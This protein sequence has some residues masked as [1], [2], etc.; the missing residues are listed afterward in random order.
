MSIIESTFKILS[1]SLKKI[2]SCIKGAIMSEICQYEMQDNMICREQVFRN[3]KGENDPNE[4]CI[5]HSEDL[6]GKKYRFE[7]EFNRKLEKYSS[8]GL[9]NF[10]FSGYVFPKIPILAL[11]KYKFEKSVFFNNAVFYFSNTSFVNCSFLGDTTDFS[12]TKFL[13]GRTSFA[14]SKFEGKYTLFTEAYFSGNDIDFMDVIFNSNGTYFC[15]TKFFST[16]T[17]FLGTLFT[18]KYKAFIEAQFISE[19]T[20]FKNSNFSGEAVA[21]NMA[22]FSG[23]NLDFSTSKFTKNSYVSFTKCSFD[24]HLTDFTKVY[25][26]SE[27]TYF[28]D[29]NICSDLIDFSYSVFRGKCTFKPSHYEL[30]NLK[31]KEVFFADIKGFVEIFMVKRKY[32]KVKIPGINKKDKQKFV[33]LKFITD[34]IQPIFGDMSAS[35]Y[36]VAARNIKDDWFLMEF[37]QKHWG[38]YKL[39]D[40]L[41]DCGRGFLRW[42][43]WS[44]FIALFFTAIYNNIW[45]FTNG[46]FKSE[47]P[48]KVT[49]SFLQFLYYSVV[50]FTTLGFGDISPLYISLQLII[51][52]E[53]IFGYIML[54]GLIS[55]LAV[56]LARRS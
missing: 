34:N 26:E 49:S 29:I 48:L 24:N 39:W 43:L 5:F 6:D 56:K 27:N 18:G 53:V 52:C 13:G 12:G 14:G 3:S 23:T 36:P 10:D 33:K 2:R 55:I 1:F 7:E 4:Y 15:N 16:N 47:I 42:S 17:M 19:N 37:S 50:T 44:I 40:W 51:M 46:G 41:A 21:F 32:N 45:F 9:S 35:K 31:M 8:N 28:R 25:F 38:W 54:G 22:N 20:L 11:V 30:N